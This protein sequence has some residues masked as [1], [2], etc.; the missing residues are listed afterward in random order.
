MLYDRE[1]RR[2]VRKK[3]LPEPNPTKVELD[4]SSTLNS[5]FQ[6]AK[7]LYFKDMEGEMMLGDSYGTAIH[8]SEPTKWSLGNF[9]ETNGLQP[10]RYKLYVIMA[11]E[12]VRSKIISVII[13]NVNFVNDEDTQSQPPNTHSI[14][15][16]LKIIF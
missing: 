14:L 12:K 10:S 2:G 6:F 15:T 4:R 16:F 11:S 13:I 1:L 8:V 9:F 7:N 5:I 3:C